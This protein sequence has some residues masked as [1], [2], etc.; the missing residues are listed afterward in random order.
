[1]AHT[2]NVVGFWDLDNDSTDDSGNGKNGTDTSMSYDGTYG[3]FSGSAYVTLPTSLLSSNVATISC[4][5]NASTIS[6]YRALYAIYTGNSDAFEVFIPYGAGGGADA[7]GWAGAYNTAALHGI[8]SGVSAST[9]YHLVVASDGSTTR[10]YLN[11]SLLASGATSF[12]TFTPAC[13]IGNR[14]GLIFAGSIRCFALYSDDKHAVTNW[15]TDDYNS[16]TA[17][18]WADWAGGGGY[19]NPQFPLRFAAGIG[20]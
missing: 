4:W 5:F 14:G 16:G 17:K 7:N 18:K 2:D 12:S 20:A 9:L 19:I 6:N 10:V 8:F 1:M 15:V 3:V 13:I 11:G